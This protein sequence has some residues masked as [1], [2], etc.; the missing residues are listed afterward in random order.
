MSAVKDLHFL[1][2]IYVSLRNVRT[3][4]QDRVTQTAA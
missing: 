2:K 4:L 3:K 1:L